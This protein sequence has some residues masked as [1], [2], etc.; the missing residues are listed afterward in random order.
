MRSDHDLSHPKYRPD[1]DG[2]RAIAVLSV[3][4]YHCF[5]N[6]LKGGFV[7][8]D[9]FFVISGYLI[10]KIIFQNLDSNSFSYK[11]FYERRIRRIFPALATVLVFCAACGWVFLLSDEYRQLGKHIGAGAGFVS[12]LV[13]WSEAG[14]F[15]T[16]G[17]SKPLLHLWSL[18]VEEQFYIFWPLLLAAGWVRRLDS[19]ALVALIAAFSFAVNIVCV[20]YFPVAAFFSPIARTWE[21]AVG[22]T[23]ARLTMHDLFASTFRQKCDRVL[24]RFIFRDNRVIGGR[25]IANASSVAGI[26]LIIFGLAHIN[27]SLSFPGWWALLPVCGSALVIAGGQ[28]AWINRVVLSNSVLVFCGIISYPIYLWHWPLLSFVRIVSGSAPSPAILVAVVALTFLLAW[29]TYEYIERPF[30][31]G[32]SAPKQKVLLLCTVLSAIAIFGTAIYLAGGVPNRLVN[33]ISTSIQSGRDGGAGVPLTFDCG[34]VDRTAA[35]GFICNGDPRGE[36]TY[37][38]VGDS[39]ALVLYPG[40]VRTSSKAGHWLLIAWYGPK[41]TPDELHLTPN[42]TAIRAVANNESVTTVVLA[43]ATRSLFHLGTDRDIEGLPS[44]PDSEA[45]YASL[46]NAIE[47]LRAAGKRIVLLIDNP[48]LPYPEECVQ[49]RTGVEFVNQFLK[50]EKPACSLSLDRHLS[51]ATKYREVL[52]RIAADY[53]GDV[54]LFDSTGYLCD[55]ERNVCRHQK[56]GRFLYSI[57]DHISD[58]AAGLIGADLNEFVNSKENAQRR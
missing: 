4:G 38:L 30:R 24:C 17:E 9:I 10:S 56:N 42:P 53:P 22:A 27:R 25:T 8:V 5:P 13:L 37:A 19:L 20:K 43:I 16:A 49:R 45:V 28:D 58:Y 18:G 57:T 32:K 39:K 55:V 29:L 50:A 40:L 31:F 54:R 52:A 46:R 51:L 41:G 12:N 2:L 11:T 15:D 1:I 44:S 48:T 14:Y 35:S 21:L 3:V 7:G 23:L 26:F 33:E 6:W 36:N 47:T 34:I